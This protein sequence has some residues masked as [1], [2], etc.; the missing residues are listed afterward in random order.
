MSIVKLV[1]GTDPYCPSGR[2]ASARS[3]RFL[4]LRHKGGTDPAEGTS[5]TCHCAFVQ[6]PVSRA[7]IEWNMEAVQC[8]CILF[9]ASISG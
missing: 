7:L 3:E 5:S 6:T 8:S 9:W 1:A 2:L 4:E